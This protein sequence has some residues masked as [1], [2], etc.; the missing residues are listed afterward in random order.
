MQDIYDLIVIGAGP[1]G[2]FASISAR[3]D[4]K[5]VLLL[6]KMPQIA[7]KLKATGGGKCNLTNTLKQDEFIAKFG[8]NEKKKKK[9]LNV[10]SQ[11]DLQD[12]FASIGVPTIARDGFRVFP[13]N[14]S[15]SLIL[16]AL[17]RKLED[18]NV[19]VK[20]SIKIEKKRE[21]T[22]KPLNA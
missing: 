11:K 21:Q 18:E 1:A 2:I 6:E 14:H 5:R 3:E 8:R 20:T 17:N 22:K 10:F 12:F 13:I 19:E 15:S 7:L 16:D 9:A 4:K